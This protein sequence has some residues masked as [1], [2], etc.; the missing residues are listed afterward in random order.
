VRARCTHSDLVV[1]SGMG[2]D[3]LAGRYTKLIDELLALRM[4]LAAS[5]DNTLS[6]LKN[7]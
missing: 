1:N 6:H 7:D 2:L 5:V 4:G 3:E